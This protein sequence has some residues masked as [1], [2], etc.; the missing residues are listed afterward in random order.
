MFAGLHLRFIC[1]LVNVF[2]EYGNIISSLVSLCLSGNDSEFDYNG[3]GPN[4]T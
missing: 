1:N 4:T 3:L 2:V